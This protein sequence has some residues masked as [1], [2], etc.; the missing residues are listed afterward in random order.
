[1][2]DPRSIVSGEIMSGLTMSITEQFEV[3]VCSACAVRFAPTKHFMECRRSDKA[4]FYC[5]NG[6]GM[7]Y[8]ESEADRLRRERDRL[9]QNESRLEVELSALRVQAAEEAYLRGR[10][11]RK[12]KAHQTRAAHG[13]CPCCKRTFKELGR[14]M[15]SKHPAFVA[16]HPSMTVRQ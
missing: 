3:T 14:H 2:A 15:A 6:H 4:T 9:K 7:S 10:A 5:P 12:L 11:E 13:T 8:T 16:E 1:V